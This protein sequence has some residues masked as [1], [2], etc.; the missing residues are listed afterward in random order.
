MQGKHQVGALITR[1]R[2]FVGFSHALLTTTVY[3]IGKFE[4]YEF[5]SS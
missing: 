5:I 4:Y 2:I 1:F 3:T